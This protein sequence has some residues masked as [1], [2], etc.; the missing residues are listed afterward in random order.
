MLDSRRYTRLKIDFML[1]EMAIVELSW[2][3]NINYGV[4]Q[5]IHIIHK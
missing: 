1:L 3:E 4:C 2:V 5:C